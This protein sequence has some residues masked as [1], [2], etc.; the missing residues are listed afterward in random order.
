M[1]PRKRLQVLLRAAAPIVLAAER[2]ADELVLSVTDAGPGVPDAERE[3]LFEPFS[4]GG[5]ARAEISGYGLGLALA[6][7]VA[8]VH[9]GLIEAPP[10]SSG[11][12]VELRLP[13]GL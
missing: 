8:E 1:R 2:V 11:F 3:R 7:R 10:V 13:L 4:R 9:G 12:R 6:R 5:R